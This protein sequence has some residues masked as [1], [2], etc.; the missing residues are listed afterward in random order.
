MTRSRCENEEISFEA[1]QKNQNVLNYL[2][3]YAYITRKDPETDTLIET[4]VRNCIARN[5]V[6]WIPSMT[7]WLIERRRQQQDAKQESQDVWNQSF[8]TFAARQEELNGRV[9]AVLEKL[10]EAEE[11]KMNAKEVLQPASRT[12]HQISPAAGVPVGNGKESGL[13]RSRSPAAPRPQLTRRHSR[14]DCYNISEE[15]G[16]WHVERSSPV[17]SN[18]H[19]WYPPRPPPSS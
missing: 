9:E 12:E 1:V 10:L 3:Y 8:A 13:R 19:A 18:V 17:L 16:A 6:S 2:Y 11:K 5:D 14:A 7:S 4:H 15:D